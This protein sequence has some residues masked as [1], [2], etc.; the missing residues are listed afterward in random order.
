MG[1]D[2]RG[3][4]LESRRHHAIIVIVVFHLLHRF[5]DVVR[6]LLQSVTMPDF[7][8]L[9]RF[10]VKTYLRIQIQR[11]SEVPDCLRL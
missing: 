3:T 1:V 9:L 11:S 7:Q 10:N 2:I 8:F 5:L 6:G 4:N